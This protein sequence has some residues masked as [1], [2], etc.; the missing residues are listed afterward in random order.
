M[1]HDQSDYDSFVKSC[2][3]IYERI[4]HPDCSDL[5][6][7]EQTNPKFLITPRPWPELI[8]VIVSCNIVFNPRYAP[9]SMSTVFCTK[10]K[11][12]RINKGYRPH[13]HLPCGN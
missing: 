10:K 13:N 2:P 6:K 7:M 3:S 11:N 9:A 1:A 5:G 8:E 4:D 12:D